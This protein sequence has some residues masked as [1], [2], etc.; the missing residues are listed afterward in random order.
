MDS[1]YSLLVVD[2]EPAARYHILNVLDWGKLGISGLFE[3]ENGY[4]AERVIGEHGPD[5]IIL[6][7]RMPGMSGLELLDRIKAMA[8][9]VQVIVSSGYSDFEAA[10][11]M[12][13]VGKVVD[14]LLKPISEDILIEAVIK[15][16]DN[17]EKERDNTII[18]G[19]YLEAQQKL[20]RSAVK[21]AIFAYTGDEQGGFME[22]GAYAQV[23]VCDTGDPGGEFRDEL[24]RT[25]EREPSLK[26]FFTAADPAC[27]V[28]Y[29]ES[30]TDAEDEALR[31]CRGL[32]GRGVK[33]GLGRVFSE[34]RYAHVSYK[35]A[36]IACESSLLKEGG[37]LITIAGHQKATKEALEKMKSEE[38]DSRGYRE[39]L[40]KKAKEYIEDNYAEPLT[41]DKVAGA[42]FVNTSYLS[43]IFSETEG[44][45]FTEYV[46]KIRLAHAKDL[47]SH[48]RLKI[49]EVA[50]IVG[51]SNAK[52]FIKVFK[53]KEGLTP[54][55][56]RNKHIFD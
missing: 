11:K 52:Y 18:R 40:V 34:S 56:Y 33:I 23:G 43:H 45:V 31:V 2:D 37:R 44:M 16:I 35:E 32:L 22:Q 1:A 15:C 50:E 24:K 27:F 51:Y 39:T 47:L 5:I 20:H 17:I 42:L 19:G 9:D 53:D 6:D 10:R 4:E 41:L 3:A 29:F 46:T 49:Y 54:A 48:K 36:L 26:Y 7:I 21:E 28:L 55:G 14:Y 12:L 25:V 30:H 13:S 38:K 8:T